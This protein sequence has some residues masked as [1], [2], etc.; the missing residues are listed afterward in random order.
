MSSSLPSTMQAQ[1]LA[2]FNQPYQLTTLPLP[3]PT[4]YDLL[5]EVGAASYCHTDLVYASGAM[6]DTLPLI[7]CHEFAG[8]IVSAG[9]L[10]FSAVPALSLGTRVGVPGRSYRPCTTCWECR[11]NDGDPEG[12]SVACPKGGNLGITM[13]GGFS[14]YALV[15]ARQVARLPDELTE[16]EAA[17][18]MCAGLTIFAALL[19]CG[20]N[21]GGKVGI[22]GCG[23]GL[24]HLGLQFGFQMGLEVV[25]VDASDEALKLAR[26]LE[27]KAKIFDARTTKAEVLL[28]EIGEGA[29]KKTKGESGLDAVLILPENQRGFDYG[30]KLLRNHGKCVVLSFPTSGFQV[31]ASDLVFRDIQVIGSL[32]G[33]N[34]VLKQMLAFAAE[35]NVR[36]VTRTYP[37]RDLNDLVEE[38]QTGKGGKLVIDMTL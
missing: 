30:M 5:I 3:T 13:N 12:Y 4:D 31:S 15:D 23:G 32:V 18:L 26:S 21:K 24:G 11:N 17:P 2:A 9:P 27:T 38:Y 29:D 28:T 37:L 33:K 35:K 19:K 8:T 14:Q 6:G 36:A 16:I 20:L 25:G 22:I 1:I 34:R 7:P 10:A